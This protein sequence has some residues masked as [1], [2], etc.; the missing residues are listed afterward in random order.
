MAGAAM[1][2]YMY[3]SGRRTS[4]KFGRRGVGKSKR[5]GRY[6]AS[7][8]NS[9][10]IASLNK[11]LGGFEGLELKFA[12]FAI[13]ALPVSTAAGLTGGELAPTIAGC[14]NAVPRGD[15]P[16]QR[17]G[18]FFRMRSLQFSLL[19]RHGPIN[20]LSGIPPSDAVVFIAVVL[21]KQTNGAQLSSED[22][23]INP[24]GGVLTNGCPL[25]NLEHTDRFRVLATRTCKLN[26]SGNLGYA[27]DT[28]AA[29]ILHNLGAIEKKVTINLRLKNKKV[30][31]TDTTGVIA[32]IQDNSVHLIAFTNVTNVTISANARMRFTT[33]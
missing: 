14:F 10:A 24:N 9:R 4:N 17:L 27:Y 33:T 2:N 5:R 1:Y 30:L 15:G 22:V 28:V 19:V 7:H 21:D 32:N 23:Y 26:V 12:D 6:P 31:M 16:N 29:D 20:S 13:D 11:R 18:R 25:R 3:G 8:Q